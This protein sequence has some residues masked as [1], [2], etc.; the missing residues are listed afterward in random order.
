MPAL[1]RDD[2]AGADSEA[3]SENWGGGGGAGPF[4]AAG[5]GGFVGAET[6]TLAVAL[7]TG[8]KG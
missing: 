5:A 2:L 3:K 7:Q 6:V 1:G 4:G 8:P